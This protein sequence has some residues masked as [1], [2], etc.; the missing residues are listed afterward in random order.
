MRTH[1]YA[2]GATTLGGS[3]STPTFKRTAAQS[4]SKLIFP[5]SRR[6]SCND[7]AGSKLVQVNPS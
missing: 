5:R 3:G 2:S 1:K 4:K 6:C 7:S